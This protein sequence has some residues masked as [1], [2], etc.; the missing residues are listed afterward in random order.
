MEGSC[1]GMVPRAVLTDQ[2]LGHA[3]VRL[4]GVLASYANQRF[5]CWPSQDTLRT[6]LGLSDVR[7]VRTLIGQL[8]AAGYLVRRA[9][10]GANGVQVGCL[11]RLCISVGTQQT[12]PG[13][14][15]SAYPDSHDAGQADRQSPPEQTIS[16]HTIKRQNPSPPVSGPPAPNVHHLFSDLPAQAGRLSGKSDCDFD[17]FWSLYPRKVGKGQARTA[18][19]TAIRRKATPEDILSGLRRANQRWA[20]DG[21]D[22]QFIP[23]P[24]TWLNGERWADDP[25]PLPP[26]RR[27][28]ADYRERYPDIPG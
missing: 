26:P 4:Y 15:E 8:E 9:R 21:T 24:A 6:D 16:E 11:Y 25:L 17:R 10:F 18:W 13:T 5:E 2:S 20:D 19:G 7:G 14:I 28:V 23:H 22:G 1:F 3:A 12:V 27:A